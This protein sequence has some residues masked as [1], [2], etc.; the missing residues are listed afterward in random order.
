MEIWQTER[1]TGNALTDAYLQGDPRIR[2]R[3]EFGLHQSDALKRRCHTVDHTFE[4]N[5]RI[6]LVAALSDYAK[7]LGQFG[8]HTTALLDK[9]ADDRSMVVVTGQQAGLFTGPLYTVYKALSAVALAKQY[10]QVMCRPIVPV[11][12]IATEDHD[13]DEV[14][15]AYYV[16]KDAKLDKVHLR[17]RPTGRVPVGLHGVSEAEL[18]KMLVQL[19]VDLPEGMYK[20]ELLQAIDE[21]YRT[22]DNMG[23]AFARLM[24]KLLKE[25][26]ILFLNPIRHNLRVL[27]KEAFARVIKNPRAFIEAAHTGT[28]M[29]VKKGFS[30]QVE[31]H[32][33]HSLLFLVD[34]GRRYALDV[35]R[36]DPTHFRLRDSDLHYTK[37]ALLARLQENPSDFSSGVLYRPVVQDFLLPVLTYVG[38]P[39]EI[40]Y[41]GMMREI[42]SEAG[43]HMPIMQLRMRV[44]TVPTA[45]T[46]ALDHLGVRLEDGLKRDL[47]KE[48]LMRDLV[49]SLDAVLKE[50]EVRMR[51]ELL[52]RE[53][54]FL[55]IDA[56]LRSSLERA[57]EMVSRS[58]RHLENRSMRALELKNQGMV[59]SATVL[60]SWLRPNQ[61]E[62]ER[63]LS[64]LSL[65]IKYGMSWFLSLVELEHSA[66]SATFVRF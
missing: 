42:F 2:D 33:D 23:D 61:T 46:R 41:H 13:F 11:F 24:T 38:G 26:P 36:E 21:S 4:H 55:D 18:D 3:F 48:S 64:P 14:A 57:Q 19:T 59:Y 65:V 50:M 22:T 40:A 8:A 28:E 35:D 44:T 63:L 34:E 62:Q 29:L 5:H 16:T 9:L 32:P 31:V 20:A 30:P 51:K 39:A 49:P 43:R 56:T 58:V 17:E 47:L 1:L 27:V 6:A 10:E 7:E 25:V 45:V 12:W 52:S 54:Y 53:A 37:T 15:A 66:T 60:S